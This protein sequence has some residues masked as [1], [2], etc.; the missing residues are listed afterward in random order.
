MERAIYFDA[1]QRRG[2]CQH[3]SMPMRNLDMIEDLKR[4]HATMLVWSAMGGGS[5]SLP[6]LEREINGIPDPRLRIYGYLNER[7]YVHLCRESG[8][9]PFAIVY[10]VQDWE[11]PAKFDENGK[12]TALNVTAGDSEDWYGLREFS[13]GTHDAAFP[14]TLKDYYPEGII[15]SAGE[16]VTDLH[17]EAASLDQYGNPI[18]AK[19]VEVKGRRAECYQACRNNPVWRNYL[20]KIIYMQAKGGARAIQLD[21]CELPMTSMGSGGCF[22]RD[23]VSQFTEFL[24]ARRDEE[25]LGP[26]WNGI[27]VESF[28]YRDYLNEQGIRFHKQAPFYRDYWEFQMRAV[29]KYFTELADYVHALSVEFGEKMRVSG[30]FYNLMPTYYPIQPTVDVVITEMAHTLLHQPYFFRY[31]A[32]FGGGK[33]VIVTENPYG[34]M[35]AEL[36]EMLDRGRGYDLYRVFLMEASVY[37]CNMSIPYGA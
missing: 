19:W 2:A 6:Y 17:R 28:N 3:P 12:L 26:E 14:T 24:K 36:L 29:K 18:H 11:F 13:N 8:I 10:E 5:I 4:Y 25:K 27:D 22:C 32:G 1:W 15:N 9:D 31:C 7:E 35:M 23:C 37:G 33:P 21:E 16:T 30:N 34:G 20:K